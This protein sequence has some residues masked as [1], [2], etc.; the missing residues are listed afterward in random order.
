[1]NQ[2]PH[3]RQQLIKRAR[4]LLCKHVPAPNPLS[5]EGGEELPQWNEHSTTQGVTFGEDNRCATKVHGDD[6]E[7]CISLGKVVEEGKCTISCE[8]S[9]TESDCPWYACR[10]VCFGVMRPGAKECS[11]GFPSKENLDYFLLN[12]VNGLHGN[13][14][15]F[16]DK[17]GR[18][19]DGQVLTMEVDLDVGTLKFW[20][21]GKPHGSGW[22]SGVTGPVQVVAK[23]FWSNA[24]SIHIVPTP[25]L[26]PYE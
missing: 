17:A 3:N 21:D 13:G 23:M 14:K 11:E 9:G 6:W 5:D 10:S 12:T 25:E 8:L 2:Q 26:Q 7:G 16:S 4:D 19:R 24:G 20:V 22:T 15:M 18:I 1:M